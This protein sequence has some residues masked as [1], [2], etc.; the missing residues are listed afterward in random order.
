MSDSGPQSLS[1]VLSK[2]IALRGFA[3][4]QGDAQLQAAW[5]EVAGAAWAAKS[6]PTGIRRGVL[7]VS[8]T[9]GPLLSE[10][11]S[12]HRLTLVARLAEKHPHLKIRDLKFRLDGGG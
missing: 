5:A 8:V 3:R 2:L 10:L 12:F 11:V 7:Q 6:R 1:D 4:K 9:E